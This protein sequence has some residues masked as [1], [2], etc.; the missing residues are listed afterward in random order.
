MQRDLLNPRYPQRRDLY[1]NGCTSN[2]MISTLPD[3]TEWEVTAKGPTT[4]KHLYGGVPH[5]ST[6]QGGY[7]MQT[8]YRD[9]SRVVAGDG[10]TKNSFPRGR[11]VR[12][13][14]SEVL[15]DP[16]DMSF[17]GTP[18]YYPYRRIARPKNTMYGQDNSLYLDGPYSGS[19]RGKRLSWHQKLYPHNNR[20]V[21]EKPV[22]SEKMLSY[23]GPRRGAPAGEF[24]MHIGNHNLPVDVRGTT[25]RTER[26][27]AS[28]SRL[29]DGS[30]RTSSGGHINISTPGR[31]IHTS[32]SLS[33]GVTDH[34]E[35]NGP[36]AQV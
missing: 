34:F 19:G 21:R 23:Q 5:S 26:S 35:S 7:R 14:G 20:K 28:M 36:Y 10:E 6:M 31:R 30:H 15:T 4:I 2:V 12:D 24:R 3:D 25:S 1:T 27:E 17:N 13:S 33:G 11:C 16:N 29:E 8:N 9:D 22:Y 18:N 32:T